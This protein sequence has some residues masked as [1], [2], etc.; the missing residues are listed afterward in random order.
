MEGTL[1]FR[2]IWKGKAAGTSIKN[3]GDERALT[4]L[5][6]SL[7]DNAMQTICLVFCR[8][9]RYSRKVVCRFREHTNVYF[10]FRSGSVPGDN[11]GP[12]TGNRR[13]FIFILSCLLFY[14][15]KRICLIVR[16]SSDWQL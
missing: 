14:L 15:L 13:R 1:R 9:V 6:Y 10:L 2:L 5:R 16:I 8:I 3:N 11:E 7:K 12:N 4:V